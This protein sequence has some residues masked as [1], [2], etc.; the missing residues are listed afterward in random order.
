M[1]EC[2]LIR[3]GIAETSGL[4]AFLDPPSL[5]LVL[6]LEFSYGRVLSHHPTDAPW[7]ALYQ[8]LSRYYET[9]NLLPGANRVLQCIMQDSF[10]IGAHAYAEHQ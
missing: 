3:E 4:S 7:Q 1:A 8:G 6:D 5:T 2:R 10:S 9:H